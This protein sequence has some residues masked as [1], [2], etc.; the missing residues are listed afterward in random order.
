MDVNAI[1]NDT[2]ETR[3]EKATEYLLKKEVEGD[4][5][6]SLTKVCRD[7]NVDKRKE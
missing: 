2:K 7:F 5:T 4:F 6:K 3:I 1:L